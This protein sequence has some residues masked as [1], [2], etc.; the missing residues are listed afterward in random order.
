MGESFYVIENSEIYGQLV[1]VVSWKDRERGN[2][3]PIYFLIFK[4]V[5]ILCKNAYMDAYF[6]NISDNNSDFKGSMYETMLKSMYDGLV[7]VIFNY[8]NAEVLKN[9]I[10]SSLVQIWVISLHFVQSQIVKTTITAW[11]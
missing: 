8:K 2:K 4:D 6:L 9:S 10:S 3:L 11:T 1:W 5:A 7:L